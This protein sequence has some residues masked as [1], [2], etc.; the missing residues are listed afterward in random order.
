M[1]QI[2]DCDTQGQDQGCNGG[3]PYGAYEYIQ[4]A[5]G[6][7]N[8]ND[9][10]YTAGGGVAGSCNYQSSYDVCTVV[11]YR[12]ISGESGLYQQLS[13]SSGGPV[14]VCV[15]AS[16][17]QTWTGGI[18]TSCGNSVDHCVQLTGYYNYG[19]SN[20]YWNVRNSWGSDWGINGYIWIAIGQDL[21]DIGD[22]ATVV[23]TKKV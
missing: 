1:E 2:V 19:A 22:Y 4:S 5:G 23:T 21:C 16:A 17:W 9:Y 15:D 20:A 7:E 14:S 12:S 11:S 18:L 3:W 13:S 8:Y 6:I 10:P